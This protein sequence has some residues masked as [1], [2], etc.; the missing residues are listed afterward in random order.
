MNSTADKMTT[1]ADK[2]TTTT[3]QDDLYY[4]LE[5]VIH[6]QHQEDL[7]KEELPCADCGLMKKRVE[8]HSVNLGM[9]GMDWWCVDCFIP[10]DKMCAWC[11][12][13]VGTDAEKNEDGDKL[14]SSCA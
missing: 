14:C 3:T 10:W 4:R 6:E 2:M 12:E 1:T 13:E 11:G 5:R 7:K 8:M 9:G